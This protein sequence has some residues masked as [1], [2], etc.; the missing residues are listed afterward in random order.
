MTTQSEQL[1]AEKYQKLENELVLKNRELEIET[2][3][4][5][6]RAKTMAMVSS[7]EIGKIIYQVFS[8]LKNLGVVH[9][10]AQ[11]ITDF[12]INK[13]WFNTW[14]ASDEKDYAHFV[15][16]NSFDHPYN[17]KWKTALKT[18]N[19]FYTDAYSKKEKDA[20][21]DG[22]FRFS[23]LSFISMKERIFCIKLRA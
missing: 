6:I 13:D 16:Y 12:E 11:I 20:W 3:L 1:L 4:E 22:A 23:D 18:G 10:F 9:H 15:R 7:E 5:R 14:Y 21:F 8:E 19:T 17:E 2:A